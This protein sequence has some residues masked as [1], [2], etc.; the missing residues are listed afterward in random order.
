L[1]D[2]LQR[3]EEWKVGFAVFYL[4]DKVDLWWATVHERRYEPRFDWKG[5]KEFIKDHF[6][7]V[8]LQKKKE[9]EFIQLHQG[10]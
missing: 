9:N 10:E 1:F 2:A 6:Y 5:F 4:K 8:S 3:P 7:L